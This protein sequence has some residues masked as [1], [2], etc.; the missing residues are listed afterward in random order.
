METLIDV[1]C[2][3]GKYGRHAGLPFL[4]P[5]LTTALLTLGK[6]HQVTTTSAP[7]WECVCVGVFVTTDVSLFLAECD[8]W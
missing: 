1:L 8:A 5:P 4:R 3:L 7:V 6:A 2:V